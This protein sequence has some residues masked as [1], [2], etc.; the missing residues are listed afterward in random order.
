M[1]ND[2][3]LLAHNA[4]Y[5]ETFRDYVLILTQ[6]EVLYDLILTQTEVLY[7]VCVHRTVLAVKRQCSQYDRANV[8]LS[9][10]HLT[11]LLTM[12]TLQ[13]NRQQLLVIWPLFLFTVTNKLLLLLE[14]LIGVITDTNI[15]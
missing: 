15:R 11:Q 2:D 14:P 13:Q 6:T 12:N 1:S 3:C 8:L 4:V 9:A 7:A 10:S 5:P